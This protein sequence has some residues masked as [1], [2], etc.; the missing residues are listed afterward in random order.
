MTEQ[1]F[2]RMLA[3]IAII[4]RLT[5]LLIWDTFPPA[6]GLRHFMIKAFATVDSKGS[7]VPDVKRWGRLAKLGHSIAYIWSCPWCMSIWVGALVWGISIWWPWL[8]WPAAV[9]SLGS[10]LAGW[11]NYLDDEHE[12]RSKLAER[13]L[14]GHDDDRGK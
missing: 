8:I 1:D 12:K 7:V 14:L 13:K 6:A 2:I 9:V 4:V 3:M 10:M 11:D 5:R